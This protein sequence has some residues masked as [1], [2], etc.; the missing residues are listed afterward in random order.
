MSKIRPPHIVAATLV[1]DFEQLRVSGSAG[2][3]KSAEA[4]RKRNENHEA[5]EAY[6]REK[7]DNEEW[8]RLVSMNAH[9]VPFDS[10]DVVDKL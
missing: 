10:D 1:G 9:I 5:V 2:G 8:R 6:F 4:R 3:R 7:R